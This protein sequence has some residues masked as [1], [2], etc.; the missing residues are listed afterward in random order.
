MKILLTTFI[1]L[2][3]AP[4]LAAQNDGPRGERLQRQKSQQERVAPKQ[5]RHRDRSGERAE[6]R[7]RILE[8]FDANGDGRLDETERAALRAAAEKM[9]AQ[10]GE[11]QGRRDGQVRERRE[12]AERKER[13]E[14]GERGE[15]RAERR[16]RI[17]ERF[18]IDGDGQLNDLER[19][20][21]R[22]AIEERR[23][24]RGVE[25][26]QR[27]VRGQGQRERGE[28]RPRPQR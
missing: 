20:A 9:R 17:L 24:E 2:A 22:K 6:R 5:E 23:A 18:D 19:E 25:G 4:S 3:A 13:G 26:Q 12:G 15:R 16:Q 14:A 10:R 21:L 27:R 7:Q 8:R 1:L 28:G 11:K